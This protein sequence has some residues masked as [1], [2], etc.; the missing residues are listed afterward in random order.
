MASDLQVSSLLQSV[1]VLELVSE[2]L[3]DIS[4]IL[5]ERL[6]MLKVTPVSVFWIFS[7]FRK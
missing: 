5:V 7:G 4:D 3:C 2:E 6:T 1:I